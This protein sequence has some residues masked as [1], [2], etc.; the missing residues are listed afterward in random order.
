VGTLAVV[1][2]RFACHIVSGAVIWYAL[3]LEW[4][5]DDP[6]HIVHRYGAWLFSLVYNAGFMVPE[7]VETVIGVPL[8]ARALARFRV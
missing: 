1:L 4:Y 2:L 8:L 7:T 6:G 3:D 5:A